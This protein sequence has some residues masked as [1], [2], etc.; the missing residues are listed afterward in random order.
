MKKILLCCGL[1]VLLLLSSSCQKKQVTSISITDLDEAQ[2]QQLDKEYPFI[3][4]HVID[5][6]Q[7]LREKGLS[8]KGR[9]YKDLNQDG[10][11]ELFLSYNSGSSSVYYAMY[12]IAEKGYDF[13]G[14]VHFLFFQLLPTKHN[15]YFDIQTFVR[16]YAE[17]D[18]VYV[19]GLYKYT[20]DGIGYI[21]NSRIDYTY[22]ENKDN[23][24]FKPDQ[25]DET[26]MLSSLW[27]PKDDDKYRRMIK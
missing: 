27:S 26:L 16:S 22:N 9:F 15:G 17:E 24:V 10:V 11:P 12:R 23:S 19:G 21:R 8:G 25:I 14:Y 18:K 6:Y 1:L 2:K 5:P 13:I 20:F 3:T 7:E 4:D